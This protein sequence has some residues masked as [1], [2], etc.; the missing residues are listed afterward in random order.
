MDKIYNR[1]ISF[2]HVAHFKSFTKAAKHLKSS[3]GYLSK[4]ISELERR[5]G[6]P[7]FHRNTRTL[8]LTF[9]GEALFQ[10]AVQIVEAFERAEN[11][12]ASL[13]DKVEG[14]LRITAPGAYADYLLAANLPRFFQDYPDIKLEMNL[15]GRLLN[16]VEEKTDIAIRLTH[17]PPL[18]RVAKRIGDYRMMICA[19]KAYLDKN[20]TPKNPEE[21]T[22]HDCLIYS[23]ERNYS[24]WPFSV[25]GDAI[26]VGVNPV[27]TANA[28]LIILNAAK[29]GVGIARLPDYVV[30]EALQTETVLP[31]LTEFY[32]VPIPIYAIYAQSRL[33]PPKVRAFVEFLQQI[34]LAE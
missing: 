34:H 31:L 7:V 20:G 13:Q 29:N 6:A 3:K 28:A 23:T 8:Q 16:L 10:H 27:L 4:E 25:N 18:D 30:R 15:T 14:I 26:T 9:S 21:L 19:S 2:Y 17:E 24:Q 32:P 5:M 1:L 33:I 11:S 12:M 22:Q